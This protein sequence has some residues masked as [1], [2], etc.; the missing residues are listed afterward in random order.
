MGGNV[1]ALRAHNGPGPAVPSGYGGGG[2]GSHLHN[3]ISDPGERLL[4][5]LRWI[6][7]LLLGGENGAV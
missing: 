5:E 4:F 2:H 3:G 1:A 6:C 7:S